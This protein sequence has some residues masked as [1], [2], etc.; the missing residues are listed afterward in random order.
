MQNRTRLLAVSRKSC[1][2]SHLWGRNLTEPAPAYQT[3]LMS[4]LTLLYGMMGYPFSYVHHILAHIEFWRSTPSISFWK[5]KG[6]QTKS[7]LTALKKALSGRLIHLQRYTH[8]IQAIQRRSRSERA[9]ENS[10]QGPK[11]AGE[12][13]GHAE[14]EE[15]FEVGGELREGLFQLHLNLVDVVNSRDVLYKHVQAR[16]R[17]TLTRLAFP[18]RLLHAQLRVGAVVLGALARAL[19]RSRRRPLALA[20][21]DPTVSFCSAAFTTHQRRRCRHARRVLHV[22]LSLGAPRDVGE[23][24]GVEVATDQVEHE[25]RVLLNLGVGELRHS[26]RG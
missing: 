18:R 12:C 11:V 3:I 21:R 9:H 23:L 20:Q 2:V 22:L 25:T 7:A 13:T 15:A 1:H 10:L 24:C 16:L 19:R 8:T 6:N 17:H 4:G 5:S 26:L 14:E